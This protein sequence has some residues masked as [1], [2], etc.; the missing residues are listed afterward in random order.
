MHKLS[1]F[2]NIDMERLVNLKNK[3][4]KYGDTEIEMLVRLGSPAIEIIKLV[5]ELNVQLVVM[6]S[7]GR[8]FVEELFIGSVSNVVARRSEASVLL[9]PSRGH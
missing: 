3:L 6:G 8:G 2:D 7:Q 5:T 4:S 9:I 1:E